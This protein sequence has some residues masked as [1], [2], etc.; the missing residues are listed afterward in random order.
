MK[1]LFKKY[2]ILLILVA[3]FL[4]F[5]IPVI[6]N[7]LYKIHPSCEFFSTEWSAGDALTYYGMLLG[8]TG[9]VLGVFLSIR[10]SQK[11]YREDIRFRSLP[12]LSLTQLMSQSNY[13][14]LDEIYGNGLDG[15]SKR[16]KEGIEAQKSMSEE[17]EYKEFLLSEVYFI[18][19]KD[20]VESLKTL[21]KE[22]ERIVHQRGLSWENTGNGKAL[23]A[24]PHI[25]IPLEIENVGN[26]PALRV[27][28]G[29]NKEENEQLFLPATQLRCHDQFYVHIFSAEIEDTTFGTYLLTLH[30]YDI[31]NN[32]YEQIFTLDINSD[33]YIFNLESQQVLTEDAEENK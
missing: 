26:G 23:S 14:P 8:A 28:I 9:T 25:T 2:W 13:R 5:G 12:F 32:E 19:K 3:L 16:V 27:R 11:S 31:Y 17:S 10:Y 4:L 7:S 20:G 33:G 15:L 18:I 21:P 1:N 29:L 22:Y 30:Y 6:I 24:T